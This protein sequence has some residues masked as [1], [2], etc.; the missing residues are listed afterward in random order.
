MTVQTNRHLTLID[1][2]SRASKTAADIHRL[3]F[4]AAVGTPMGEQIPAAV[5]DRLDD[6]EALHGT[7][8]DVY[9]SATANLDSARQALAEAAQAYTEAEAAWSEAGAEMNDAAVTLS[10]ARQAAGVRLSASGYVWA[11][12]P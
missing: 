7:A 4:R 3:M 1:A 6:L 2:A 9:D 11:V 10:Q 8:C 12:Q 5:I